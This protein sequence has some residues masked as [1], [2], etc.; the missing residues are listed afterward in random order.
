MKN[1]KRGKK[2]IWNTMYLPMFKH[3]R[4][5]AIYERKSHTYIFNECFEG[6]LKFIKIDDKH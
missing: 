5:Y 6:S 4:V 1:N 3:P 2:Y